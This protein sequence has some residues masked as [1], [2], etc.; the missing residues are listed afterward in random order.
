MGLIPFLNRSRSF[1][2]VFFSKHR[3]YCKKCK[4][5]VPPKGS[6]EIP[7]GRIGPIAKA[8]AAFLRYAVKISERDVRALFEKTFNLKIDGINH[9]LWKLSNKRILARFAKRLVRHKDEILTFLYV[10]IKR[11]QVHSRSNIHVGPDPILSS[12]L[13]RLDCYLFRGLK[14]LDLALRRNTRWTS[15]TLE[16]KKLLNLLRWRCSR[17]RITE[18]L[19][20]LRPDRYRASS[21]E[22]IVPLSAC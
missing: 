3:Y 22:P 9:W 4:R 19:P 2:R 18:G 1:E 20:A 16:A 13:I 10:N 14:F 12:S 6:D 17:M 21:G 8:F 7:S 15:L 5:V 11:G